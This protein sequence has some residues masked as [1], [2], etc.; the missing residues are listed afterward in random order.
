MS[1][2]AL[3]SLLNECCKFSFDVFSICFYLCK[4]FMR[5]P[6]SPAWFVHRTGLAYW[7]RV[8]RFWSR[9]VSYSFVFIRITY[10]IRIPRSMDGESTKHG[11]VFEWLYMGSGLQLVTTSNYSVIAN[12]RILQFSIA[13]AIHAGVPQGS[14]LGPLL[15]LHYT[16]D[17]PTSPDSTIATWDCYVFTRRCYA[18]A[19]NSRGAPSPPGTLPGASVSHPPQAWTDWASRQ[20][21][22]LVRNGTTNFRERETASCLGDAAFGPRPGDRLLVFPSPYRQIQ[23]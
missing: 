10:N 14:V 22:G 20:T 18:T 19:S 5:M 3:S 17:I 8:G 12:Y 16:A 1:F 2:L 7:Q 15:Y 13:L 21:L 4:S 11:H 6:S 9:Q 23:G